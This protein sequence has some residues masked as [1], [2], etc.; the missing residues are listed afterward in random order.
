MKLYLKEITLSRKFNL[1]VL[2]IGI[3]GWFTQKILA[4]IL[5]L[6]IN[7]FSNK[8]ERWNQLMNPFYIL[9]AVSL[10]CLVKNSVFENKV[11]NYVS[12]LSLL[13]YIIH[14]NRVIENYI[15]FEI[16]DYI[17]LHYT[18]ENLLLWILAFAVVF[19]CMAFVLSVIYHET[20]QKLV[21]KVS[22]S[23]CNVVVNIYKKFESI[24]V[25]WRGMLWEHLRN[26][27][28]LICTVMGMVSIFGINGSIIISEKYKQHIM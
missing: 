19:M 7:F 16:W 22:G 14:T 10:F 23:L 21:A 5:G 25:K 13:V 15:V 18:Y 24:V 8:V 3:I 11:V 20:L 2:A 6:Y 28:N 26:T 1:F 9:I 12:S 17:F 27:I 4:N